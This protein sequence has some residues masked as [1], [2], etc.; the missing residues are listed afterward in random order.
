M[1]RRTTGIGIALLLLATVGAGAWKLRDSSEAKASAASASEGRDAKRQKDRLRAGAADAQVAKWDA[2]TKAAPTDAEAWVNLGDALMEKARETADIDYYNR[3]EGT[4]KR[5]LGIAPN[6]V[7]ALDGMAWVTSGRHE[8]E[9]SREWANRAITRDP[10]DNAA[11]GLLGDADVEM[12]RYDDAFTHYQK[13][14]DLRPDIS[15]Y[16]RGAHLLYLTGDTRKALTLMEKART[17]GA[18]YAENTAW[19]ASRIAT[20]LFATGALPPA[21]QVASEALGQC[22]NSYYLLIALGKIRAARQDYPGAIAAYEKAVEITPQHDALVALGDLYTLTGRPDEAQ[23]RYDLVE[24]VYK[25]N[26]NLGMKG[27]WAMALFYANHDRNLPE[28]LHLVREEYNTR[29][30]VAVEDA[31]AWCLYKNGRFAEAREYARRALAHGTPEASYR[32][33]AGMIAAR[34]GDRADARTRLHQ[35]LDI[36]PHF[37]PVDAPAAAAALRHLESGA[38]TVAVNSL[39]LDSGA[40]KAAPGEKP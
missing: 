40:P 10:G 7:A 38:G 12:G 33:H 24:A 27:D 19:C 15:S 29:P 36:N 1:N 13:M 31:L 35:V 34:C 30:N 32:F 8:F 20:M 21:E 23:K 9:Q 14:L 11:Y 17:S 25:M 26:K 6:N 5:A 39:S 3:A 18:P 22:P 4:Y 37:D 16:S 2:R 28:A